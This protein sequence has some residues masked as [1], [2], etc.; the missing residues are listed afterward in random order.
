MSHLHDAVEG[1]EV[2][3]VVAEIGQHHGVE[4]DDPGTTVSEKGKG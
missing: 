1:L 2:K 4:S 3:L